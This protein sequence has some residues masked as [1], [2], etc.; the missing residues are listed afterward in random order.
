M[1]DLTEILLDIRMPKTVMDF[2]FGL[3]VQA[4]AFIILRGCFKIYDSNGLLI[5]ILRRW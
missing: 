5:S 2:K 1:A 4:F 3:F